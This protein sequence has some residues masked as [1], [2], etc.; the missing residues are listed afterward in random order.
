[1]KFWFHFSHRP[2]LPAIICHGIIW[3]RL[4][5]TRKIFW[6]S[7]CL[8]AWKWDS[9]ASGD[10]RRTDECRLWIDIRHFHYIRI[11]MESQLHSMNRSLTASYRMCRLCECLEFDLDLCEKGY[12]LRD[13]N[14]HNFF[15]FNAISESQSLTSLIPSKVKQKN[16]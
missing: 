9:W 6:Q 10:R 14:F 3:A 15:S 16:I 7:I 4:N 2:L 1:M 8:N 11:E 5:I 13:F 12:R